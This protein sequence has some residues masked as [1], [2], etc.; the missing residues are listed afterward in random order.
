MSDRK[1]QVIAALGAAIG[2]NCIP[3][4]D[5]LYARAR[6]IPLSEVEIEQIVETAFKVKSGAS[7]FLKKAVGEVVTVQAEAAEGCCGH[8]C[9]C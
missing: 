4:F 6:E 5:H 7:L 1:T 2:A 9:S 8:D 3:C